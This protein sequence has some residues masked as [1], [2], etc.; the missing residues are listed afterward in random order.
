MKKKSSDILSKAILI[1]LVLMVID[2][3]GGFAH[4]RFESWFKWISTVVLIV[5]LILVSVNFGKQQNNEVTYGKVFGYAFKVALVVS[6]LI[7]VYSLLSTYVI[8]PEMSDQIL[9]K[10]R[11]DLEAKGG[12]TEDQID[13]AVTMTKKF[14]QPIPLALFAFLGT[15]FFGVIGAL[16]GAAFT[17]K[18]D[19]NAFQNKP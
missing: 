3:I 18:T 17:K 10:T 9:E 5:A 13:Q 19:V 2:L 8:F 6:L 16:L 1:A 11:A 15:L 14:I 7:I 4:L 12:L